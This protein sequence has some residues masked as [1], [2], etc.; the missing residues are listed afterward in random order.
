MSEEQA[1]EAAQPALRD[2]NAEPAQSETAVGK[3]E[4]LR[5]AIASYLAE[6][7]SDHALAMLTGL[8]VVS[9]VALV[10]AERH[11]PSGIQTLGDALWN[12]LATVASV[13]ES[14]CPPVTPA[15][16][17]IGSVLI[18]L[19]NPLYDQAKQEIGRLL[20]TAAGRPPAPASDDLQRQL[21]QRLDQLL[22]HLD[23]LT[24]QNQTA[25]SPQSEGAAQP[26]QHGA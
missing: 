20:F 22:A 4:E 14:G 7:D 6:A 17:L 16:K 5:D 15:G 24:Q 10:A 23:T 8:V 13:G 12:A 26:Q 11:S 2:R 3:A 1:V 9:S 19:G 25:L 18:L 21:L